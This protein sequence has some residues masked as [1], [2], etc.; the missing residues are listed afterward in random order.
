MSDETRIFNEHEQ[1]LID[2]ARI[3]LRDGVERLKSRENLLPTNRHNRAGRNE[4][5]TARDAI[6]SLLIADYGMLRH[7]VAVA[8]LID[9][10]G[11][12]ITIEQFPQGKATSVEIRRRVLAEWIIRHGASALLLA[13]NHPSGDNTPSRDDIK[14][15]E[16]LVPWLAAMECTL[17]DHLVLNSDDASSILGGW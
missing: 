2:A 11:R 3:V 8:V 4:C 13:H 10:Q 15:T 6:T 14:L 9:A 16:Q 12:L 5:R 1:E 17:V 7:E